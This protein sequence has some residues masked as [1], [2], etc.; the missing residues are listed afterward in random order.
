MQSLC[1]MWAL[2]SYPAD[3]PVQCYGRV[4]TLGKYPMLRNLSRSTLLEQTLGWE[5]MPDSL[6]LPSFD[7]CRGAR[8]ECRPPPDEHRFVH[9]PR[10][11]CHQL[12]YAG[13][14][15][16]HFDSVPSCSHST[17]RLYAFLRLRSRIVLTSCWREQ[18]V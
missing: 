16:R 4:W 5:F 17:A 6:F 18:S 12:L 9:G 3:V 15:E 8:A 13:A 1:R 2:A 7:T 14:P 11:A 10:R